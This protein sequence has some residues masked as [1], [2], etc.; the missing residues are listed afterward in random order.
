MP[1]EIEWRGETHTLREWESITGIQRRVLNQRK[2]TGK[3]GDELFAPCAPRL[4]TAGCGTATRYRGGC[5]CAACTEAK[6]L[7]CVAYRARKK[8]TA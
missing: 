8:G 6:R 2:L 3:T 4:K 7:E 5:H 1:E